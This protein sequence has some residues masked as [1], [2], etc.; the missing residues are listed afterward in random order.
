MPV[1]AIL[2]RRVRVGVDEHEFRIASDARGGR[3][4]VE[5]SEA[6]SEG[7]V[8]LVVDGL[9]AEEDDAVR[10]EGA[11][12]LL[13]R[14]VVE[15]LAEVHPGDLGSDRRSERIDGDVPVFD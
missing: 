9:V 13:E 12:D 11:V 5:R 10:D 4:N 2:A 6:P 7:E 14:R 3:V 15:G 8:L 1:V